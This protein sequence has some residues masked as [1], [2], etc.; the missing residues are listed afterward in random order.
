[1]IV[2]GDLAAMQNADNSFTP[3]LGISVSKSSL[4]GNESW[5]ATSMIYLNFKQAALT[6]KYTKMFA[7]DGKISHVKNY[8]LTYATTFTDHLVFLGYTYIE[9]LDEMGVIGSNT[10]AISAFL[11]DGSIMLAPSFTVFYMKPLKTKTKIK[12][13]PEIFVLTSPVSYM[14]ST[15]EASINK[16]LSMML[17]NSFD[18]PLS[19]RFRINFNVK[20]SL[21]TNIA[22]PVLTFFTVGSKLNL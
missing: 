1:M 3:V 18:I 22:A 12:F 16:D 4:M 15:K 14:T 21:S 19:K 20:A 11:S 2:S 8:S 13:T 9:L 7:T 5:G 10:S 6:G 17:G